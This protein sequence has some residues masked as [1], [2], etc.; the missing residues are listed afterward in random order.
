MN[1]MFVD[2]ELVRIIVGGWFSWLGEWR[3]NATAENGSRRQKSGVKHNK[4]G[5]GVERKETRGIMEDE[6]YNFFFFLF[7]N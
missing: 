6:P 3:S 4:G 2:R 1:G 5:K 7:I